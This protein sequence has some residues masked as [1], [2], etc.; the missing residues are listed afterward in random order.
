MQNL[1]QL[2]KTL[3]V[4]NTYF[5][6]DPKTDKVIETRLDEINYSTRGVY[7]DFEEQLKEGQEYRDSQ[8]LRYDLDGKIIPKENQFTPIIPF[9]TL[10]LAE[11]NRLKILT[12]S[13]KALNK[14]LRRDIKENL[15]ILKQIKE[16]K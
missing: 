9:E 15:E 2:K 14:A 11:S 12:K 5:F 13:Y 1:E 16:G 7:F 4:G 8:F 3:K 6:T 10:A